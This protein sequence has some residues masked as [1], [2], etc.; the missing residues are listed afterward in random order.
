VIEN[1]LII[2]ASN[3]SITAIKH[4]SNT[5]IQGL[6]MSPKITAVRE[7]K[8]SVSDLKIGM[9]VCRLDKDWIDSPFLFQGFLIDKDSLINQLKNECEFVYVDINKGDFSFGK[10]PTES[11]KTAFSFKSLF[12][13]KDS[14][15]NSA[16]KR[17]H[18]Y[19]L[20]DIVEHRV[21]TEEIHPPKK[22]VAYEQEVG[23]AKQSH[24]KIN[25]L[26]Q[27]FSS[28]VKEGGTIDLLIAR[29][30]IYECMTSVLR[31]P[32]AMQLVSRL[33]SKHQSSWQHSMNDSILAIS[34]GRYLNL[35]DDELVTLGLC[36]LLHDIGNLRI[37]KEELEQAENK[38]EV[39]RTHPKLGYEILLNCPGELSK[40]VAEV[41][42]CHH[43]RLDGSGFPRG[44]KAEQISPY[45]RMISIVDV[46][47]SL[48]NHKAEKSL[49]HYNAISQ[50][51]ARANSQFDETLLNC[52]HQC[53]GTYPVGTVVEMNSG[54]IAMVVETNDGHKLKPKVMLLT[55][56]EK[57]KC[58]K[59]VI[60]LAEDVN[61]AEE[62]YVIKKIVRPE[63]YGIKL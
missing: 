43:E 31:S 59:K 27:D 56:A 6:K 7:V 18:T 54:E 60:N 62:A 24:T 46:Y 61:D 39:I 22:V 52:F 36:G 37:S 19:A 44:L 49:T 3:T 32:D 45:T 63:K 13:K 21:A 41:A 9:F 51:L 25:T 23:T 4:F 35:N 17:S 29:E 2:K 50:M 11:K 55:N 16:L 5:A 57:E 40:T 33:K 1:L 58:D 8:I 53:I 48:T 26:M 42:Y 12:A 14:G 20:R 15:K 34:F 30:A 10:T 38:K 28:Q 47:N